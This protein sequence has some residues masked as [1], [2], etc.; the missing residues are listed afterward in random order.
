MSF[1]SFGILSHI[2]GCDTRRAIIG[3]LPPN[4]CSPIFNKECQGPFAILVKDIAFCPKSVG[5][6]DY[7]M[8]PELMED[9]GLS[10]VYKNNGT[11]LIVKFITHPEYEPYHYLKH[12]LYYLYNCRHMTHLDMYCNTCFDAKGIPILPSSFLYVEEVRQ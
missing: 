9:L 4:L 11:S 12:V 5:H 2:D 1:S 10:N 3:R 7:L 8:V 6:H